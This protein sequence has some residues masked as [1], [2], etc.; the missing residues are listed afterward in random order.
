MGTFGAPGSGSNGLADNT[1]AYGQIA[2]T[3]TVGESGVGKNLQPY[4]VTLV[5]MKL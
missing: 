3:T 5:I 1:Y 4:I 2:A